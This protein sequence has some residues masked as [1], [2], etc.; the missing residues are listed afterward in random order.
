VGGA[1]SVG[2]DC[3]LAPGDEEMDCTVELSAFGE[4]TTE[5]ANTATSIMEWQSFVATVTAGADLLEGQAVAT[6]P[7]GSGPVETGSSGSGSASDS[8]SA[9]GRNGLSVV[10]GAV[11]AGAVVAAML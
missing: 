6:A 1:L 4:Q 9:A 8:S 10:A 5:T 3:A 2:M 7:P 11:M